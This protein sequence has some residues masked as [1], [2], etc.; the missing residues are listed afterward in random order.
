MRRVSRPLAGRASPAAIPPFPAC[1]A[2]RLSHPGRARARGSVWSTRPGGPIILRI[3]KRG[4][5]RRTAQRHGENQKGNK[6]RP[7]DQ[8]TYRQP[9][10]PP[11][12]RQRSGRRLC[13]PRARFCNQV[14]DFPQQSFRFVIAHRQRPPYLDCLASRLTGTTQ[15]FQCPNRPTTE[16]DCCWSIF[17][18]LINLDCATRHRNNLPRNTD[19][20]HGSR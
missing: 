11:A 2:R 20:R 15:R 18:G 4:V 10:V 14:S 3:D 13:F 19:P 17:P 6:S 9:P 16:H 7:R 1:A 8:N 5:L 12:H